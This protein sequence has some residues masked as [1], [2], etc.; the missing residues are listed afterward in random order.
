MSN[1]HANTGGIQDGAAKFS[2]Q[3]VE[4]GDL[5][6]AVTGT[7]NELQPL[8]SGPAATQFVELMNEWHKDV[9]DIKQMLEVIADKV[10]KAGLGYHDLDQGIARSFRV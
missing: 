3:S 5:I 9:N 1:I 6:T 8:W 4:L 2:H 7:L 10:D